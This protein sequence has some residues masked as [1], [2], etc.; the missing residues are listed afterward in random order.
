MISTS[1][2]YSEKIKMTKTNP[3][4]PSSERQFIELRGDFTETVKLNFSVGENNKLNGWYVFERTTK[5]KNKF[6]RKPNDSGLIDI[7]SC[8]TQYLQFDRNLG[9]LP[10]SSTMTINQSVLRIKNMI[11]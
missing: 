11:D 8:N 10:D 2:A 4:I 5:G 6:F 7:I 9:V 1:E 3:R